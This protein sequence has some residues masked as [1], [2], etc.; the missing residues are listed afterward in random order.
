MPRVYEI[1][2]TFP[3]HSPPPPD[4]GKLRHTA[5]NTTGLLPMALVPGSCWLLSMAEN[6][7]PRPGTKGGPAASLLGQPPLARAALFCC[8]TR[9]SID[10]GKPCDPG[11]PASQQD[12]GRGQ[13]WDCGLSEGPGMGKSGNPQPDAP[14]ALLPS[15]SSRA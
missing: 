10:R 14:P 12:L 3:E 5:A 4:T 1:I 11:A 8:R 6:P 9:A 15:G 13:A 7:A 2:A